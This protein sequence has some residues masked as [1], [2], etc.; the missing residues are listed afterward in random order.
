MSSKHGACIY[1][2]QI[3]RFGLAL[4]PGAAVLTHYDTTNYQLTNLFVK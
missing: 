1:V 2:K 3:R 4:K